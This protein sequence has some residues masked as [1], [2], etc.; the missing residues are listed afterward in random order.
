MSTPSDHLWQECQQLLRLSNED[1]ICEIQK[2]YRVWIDY[3]KAAMVCDIVG[4]FCRLPSRAQA[5]C[6]V[7]YG[8]GGTGKSSII[9]QLKRDRF[10]SERSVFV[11]LNV[12]PY[13]LKYNELLADAL[14]V[15]T[16]TPARRGGADSLSVELTEVIKLRSIK[17][18]VIDEFHDALLVARNEQRRFLSLLKGLSN[19]PFGVSIVAFGVGTASSALA[20]DKQM[21][22]RFQKVHLDDWEESEGFRSFLAGWERQLP[23]RKP[24]NLDNEELVTYLLAKTLGRMDDVV[25]ILRAAAC[26]AITSG[27]E[28]ITVELLEKAGASPWGY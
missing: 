6:L 2:D 1:R 12:N 3:P 23:L 26:Y 27:Q 10:I 11:A 21:S 18:L 8:E 22:R 24:S 14:G 20:S 7:A 28:C 16:T 9:R 4:Q 25:Q 15:P 5:P 13:G 19:E 17:C